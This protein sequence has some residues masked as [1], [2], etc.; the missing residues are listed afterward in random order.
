MQHG[1]LPAAL[2]CIGLAITA[3]IRP[4]PAAAADA[5]E[6]RLGLQHWIDDLLSGPGLGYAVAADGMVVVAATEDGFRATLPAIRVD[7]S[8]GAAVAIDPIDLTLTAADAE[9]YNVDWQLPESVALSGTAG[10]GRILV[11]SRRGTG[12]F[13]P[14]LGVMRQ[15]HIVLGGIGLLDGT[16][17]RRLQVESLELQTAASAGTDGTLDR[18]TEVQLRGIATTG[19]SEP[20]IRIA[21]LGYSG[22][23]RGLRPAAWRALGE[24]LRP[25]LAPGERPEPPPVLLSGFDSRY[26]ADELQF[27]VRGQPATLAGASLAVTGTGLDGGHANLSLS[28]ALADGDWPPAFGLFAARDAEIELALTGLPSD[29]LVE[30]LVAALA[31]AG[32]PQPELALAMLNMRLQEAMMTSGAELEIRTLRLA[33]D[34]AELRV[35]GTIAPTLASMWG[36]VADIEMT[37]AG[38][39]ALIAEARGAPDDGMA[40]Q[41]LTLLQA[42]G[43]EDTDPAGRPLRR[44]VLSITD[45][46]EVLLNGADLMPVLVAATP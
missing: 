39:D 1:S 36:V 4:L 11:A 3:A 18:T 5:E 8:G 17:G 22:S 28:L 42:M 19:G 23:A 37:I 14:A 24:S 26:R 32:S 29:R 20:P 6:V 34:M 16:G 9:T 43:A 10:D 31:D 12:L 25:G 15:T 45:S 13:D 27:A 35:G 38:L 21:S 30:A 33:S 46:G 2:L 41:Q 40:L 7:L 44:Y